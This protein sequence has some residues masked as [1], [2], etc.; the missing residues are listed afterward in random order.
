MKRNFDDGGCWRTSEGVNKSLRTSIWRCSNSFRSSFNLQQLGREFSSN[1]NSFLKQSTRSSV[2]RFAR[3]Q[4]SP[5]S[6][7]SWSNRRGWSAWVL[8]YRV[9]WYRWKKGAWLERRRSI[10]ML[11]C[12]YLRVWVSN[13]VSTNT[14]VAVRT[15][16]DSVR[17]S[18]KYSVKEV[19]AWAQSVDHW[20]RRDREREHSMITERDESLLLEMPRDNRGTRI[21]PCFHDEPIADRVSAAWKWDIVG[22][23]TVNST[24]EKTDTF[25]RL[26][27]PNGRH[28]R[29]C[30][31]TYWIA[32]IGLHQN[33]Q[34]A[35]AELPW[36]F[37]LVSIL[38]DARQRRG[39]FF[40][41]RNGFF[42]QMPSSSFRQGHILLPI[43]LEVVNE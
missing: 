29:W 10:P 33:G 1:S 34:F 9:V 13:G 11:I 28:R 4:H 6:V 5:R 12:A 38:N 25:A 24:K 8:P 41:R 31:C 36:N 16:T 35:C 30:R 23:R 2:F 7:S 18:T 43:I 15:L 39:F 20:T 21:F 40:K 26:S 19:I 37:N 17:K 42:A 32:P 27:F 14:G 3:N 22:W